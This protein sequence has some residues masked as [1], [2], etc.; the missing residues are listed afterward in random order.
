[1]CSGNSQTR[2]TRLS[3]FAATLE[4]QGETAGKRLHSTNGNQ[5]SVD[6]VKL[7]EENTTISSAKCLSGF[8]GFF[9]AGVC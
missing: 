8:S 4:F 2:L 1:M 7:T 6:E 3:T 9:S 5:S